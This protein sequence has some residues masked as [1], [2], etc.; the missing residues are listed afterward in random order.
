MKKLKAVMMITVFMLLALLAILGF[1]NVYYKSKQG[2][3]DNI[4]STS[5]LQSK[6]VLATA[7]KQEEEKTLDSAL[8]RILQENRIVTFYYMDK[9]V[10]V[11]E[12]IY[13]DTPLVKPQF[14]EIYDDK[15]EKNF[16]VYYADP[17]LGDQAYLTNVV[18]IKY[19]KKQ[20]ELIVNRKYCP[21]SVAINN[22][23]DLIEIQD[24]NYS[25][26]LDKKAIMEKIDKKELSSRIRADQLFHVE[27]IDLFPSYIQR[28][29]LND[30]GYDNYLIEYVIKNIDYSV[31]LTSIMVVV[32]YKND[33]KILDAYCFDASDGY[34]Y[35]D[36]VD[37]FRK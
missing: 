17:L 16:I 20:R 34:R 15:D 11:G 9:A 30:D 3:D 23:D 4:P 25:L 32:D 7:S 6:T 5:A 14:I 12:T 13:D 28:V 36:A 10:E 35:E 21:L 26:A 18:F 1:R 19:D 37:G 22:R 2:V 31:Y 27:R 33:F 29:D 24:G 8:P